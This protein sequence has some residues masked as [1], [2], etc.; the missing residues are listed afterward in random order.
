MGRT[1]AMSKYQITLKPVDKFFFGGDMTFKVEGQEGFNEQYSSYIIRSTMFPQQTSLLGMLRFLLLRNGGKDVFANGQIQNQAMA[2]ALIGAKS[3]TVNEGLH[4]ENAFGK[5][6]SLSHVKVRR[7]VGG[8]CVDL[9]FAPLFGEINFT[10]ASTGSYNLGDFCTPDIPKERYN[11]KDGLKT[12]LTDGVNTYELEY[13]PENE[14]EGV[15]VEDRR[16]GIDRDIKTGK[17]DD[18]ALFKQVSYRFSDRSHYCFVF[19]VEVE[20]DIL[21]DSK[22]YNGQMVSIGGD[23]SQFIIGISDRIISN[24][25]IKPLRNAVYL[26]SPTFLTRSEARKA[27]FAV[28]R[29]RSFRFLTSQNM[30]DAKSYHILSSK[31]QRSPKYELYDA[32]SVFYFGNEEEKKAFIKCIESK[33]EFRQIGYNEYK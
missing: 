8:Q 3:F 20:D 31:M 5:I 16:I 17:T 12:L 7:E 1:C 13:H 24:P 6:K 29:L 33:R 21:L 9:D 10:N 22:E 28:T 23:N 25:D 2:D 26:L 11:A 18:G 4:D 19:D 30:S 15:F 32:G 27:K 14:Q